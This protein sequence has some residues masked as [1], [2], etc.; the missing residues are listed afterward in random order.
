MK[1]GDVLRDGARD[2]LDVRERLGLRLVN[3]LR[4]QQAR[5]RVDDAIGTWNDSHNHDEVLAG[6]DNA[7]A[8]AELEGV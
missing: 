7:I 1:G 8:L 5:W 4:L 6:F 3:R 2:G